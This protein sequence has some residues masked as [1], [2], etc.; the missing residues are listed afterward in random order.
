MVRKR[1][2]NISTALL[3]KQASSARKMCFGENGTIKTGR[4]ISTKTKIEELRNTVAHG[5]N[6]L[7]TV[8]IRIAEKQADL[9]TA[10]EIKF[11]THS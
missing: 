1:T 11:P 7:S 9:T 4:P 5:L 8:A 2:T 10:C 3:G 6:V